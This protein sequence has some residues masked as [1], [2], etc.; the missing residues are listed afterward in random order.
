[1]DEVWGRPVKSGL[2]IAGRNM[3]STDAVASLVMDVDPMT[4]THI[5]LAEKRGL[6][7]ANIHEIELM[8]ERLENVRKHFS[9]SLSE[10]KLQR[11]YGLTNMNISRAELKKIWEKL[12]S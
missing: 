1:M 3:V 10:E 11:V 9:T 7:T 2:I 8:G 5:Q 4:V 12:P 6:G